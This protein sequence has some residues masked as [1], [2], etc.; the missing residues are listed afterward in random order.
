ME[1]GKS[2]DMEFAYNDKEKMETHGF[3]MYDYGA[4]FYD[5]TIGRWHSI[6]PLAEKYYSISPY[7]YCANNPV[8]NIDPDGRTI[9][10]SDYTN[11]IKTDYEWKEYEG[12]WGFYDSYNNIYADNDTFIGQLSRALMKLMNGGETGKELVSNLSGMTDIIT[13]SRGK[14]VYMEESSTVGWN[15]N[16]GSNVPTQMGENSNVAFVS[17]G[18][19]LGHAWDYTQKTANSTSWIYGGT[20][21]TKDIPN[22]EIYSTHMEN[23]IR[24]ENGL[25]LRTHYLVNTDGKGAGPRIIDSKGRSICY[26]TG[27]TTNY[28]SVKKITNSNIKMKI[29]IIF[30]VISYTQLN[31]QNL[32]PVLID[33]FKHVNEYDYNSKSNLKE[34][35]NVSLKL[36]KAKKKECNIISEA[37]M[38][39]GFDFDQV[40]DTLLFDFVYEDYIVGGGP[41]NIYAQS[42]KMVKRLTIDSYKD[43]SYKESPASEKC[44][45]CYYDMMYRGDTKTLYK[46]FTKIGERSLGC[47]KTALRV[48]IKE[49]KVVY[50]S[51][52]WNYGC[53][54]NSHE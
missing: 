15:P 8:K 30:L 37:L 46:I 25:Q 38:K 42:S 51:L 53:I 54:M 31:S 1:W 24:A 14:N 19:E 3:N 36:N 11:N 29:I 35:I 12:I 22:S 28:K 50:P 34:S 17:L 44:E 2:Y 45:N 16:G 40:N 27:N 47:Y 26:N 52:L 20:Y 23:K 18:H 10:V 32:Y 13:I 39:V 9:R 7:A 49:R 6:D 21:G 33:A 41:Y 43:S 5:Q 4:R 48:I